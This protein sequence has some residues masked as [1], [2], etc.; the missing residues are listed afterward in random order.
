MVFVYASITIREE[1]VH[2]SNRNTAIL[3]NANTAHKAGSIPQLY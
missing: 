3:C 2:E 1:T